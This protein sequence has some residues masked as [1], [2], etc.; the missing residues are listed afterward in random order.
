MA[1]HGVLA[2]EVSFEEFERLYAGRRYEYVDGRAVPMGL[3]IINP[4]GE[5][6][7]TPTKSKHGEL[8]LELGRLIGNFVREHNLGKTFGAETGFLMQADPPEVR[9]EDV[10]FISASRTAQIDPDEWLP[11]PPDLAV[12][13]VS[14][15]ERAAD[16]RRKAQSY[17]ERG[18]RL[19]LIVYPDT[20]LIDAYRPG[21][22]VLTL[23]TADA[24]DGGDV[25]PGFR[26]DVGAL[27][28]ILDR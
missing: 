3:E 23:G 26:L 7:V 16:I 14:E 17:M 15:Y 20:K 21:Q 19:L 9:A 22:P 10:A 24:L 18:T 8:A 11:F 28:A 5:V 2:R 6:V 25:L 27:F 13:I 4:D 1:D 12:E